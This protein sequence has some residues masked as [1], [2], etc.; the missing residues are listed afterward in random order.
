MGP[1]KSKIQNVTGRQPK[2]APVEDVPGVAIVCAEGEID[3]AGIEA[4]DFMLSKASE[5]TTG[6]VIDLSRA[7]HVDY[8]A[9]TLLVARRRVFKARGG[10][11]AVAA[12][13]A[14]VRNILRASAGAEIP[15]FS[16]LD[17]AIAYVRGE[18]DVVTSSAGKLAKRPRVS[19]Q[20]RS[21]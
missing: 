16:T 10:E 6:A 3:R 4:C 11:L 19:K 2:L 8:R 5:E 21:V 17:E 14:E 18:A 9:T 12:G 20:P 7:T 13:R 1:S 15:V